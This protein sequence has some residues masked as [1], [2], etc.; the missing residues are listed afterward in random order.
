VQEKYQVRFGWGAAGAAR[1][2]AGAHLIAWVDV[3]PDAATAAAGNGLEAG[4]VPASPPSGP[5]V[6]TVGLTDG[7]VVA[8]RVSSLQTELGDRC[9]VAVVA[10]GG[11]DG[12][13]TVEDLLGAGNVID[14]LVAIGIDHT[15]PEAAAACA[16]WT[17]LHRAARHLVSASESAVALHEAG[18]R[19]VV[20]RAIG[21]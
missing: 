6:L 5:E 4:V 17:G 13:F 10:A 12:A 8:E 18:A 19:E 9:V 20:D 3:L 16:A 7:T 1:I 15:S 2:A 14:A 11:T 21:R